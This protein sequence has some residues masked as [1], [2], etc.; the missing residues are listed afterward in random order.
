MSIIARSITDKRWYVVRNA[1]VILAR[2]GDEQALSFLKKVVHHE[3]QKVRRELVNSLEECA[4][5]TALEI[6]GVMVHDPDDEIRQAAVQAIVA[7]RGQKAFEVITDIINDHTFRKLTRE[8]QQQLLNA[9]SIIG[10]DHAVDYLSGLILRANPLKDATLAFFREGAFEALTLN[11]SEK[12]EKF[13]LKL[14]SSWRPQLKQQATAAIKK[15][16]EIIYGG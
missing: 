7:R 5:E 16:R 6:L 9:Y 4:N 2:I 1:V 13:L 12:S 14:T 10:G 8:N 3:Q 15:R 11:R